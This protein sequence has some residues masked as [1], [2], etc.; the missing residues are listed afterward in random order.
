M[1]AGVG[2]EDGEEVELDSSEDEIVRGRSSKKK[3]ELDSSEDEIPSPKRS[4]SKM[5]R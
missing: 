3:R 1:A 2:T 5:K 4:S